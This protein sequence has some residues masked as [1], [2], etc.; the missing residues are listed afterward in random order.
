MNKL[1]ILYD[2]VR[3]MRAKEAFTGTVTVAV[4]KDEA[5]LFSLRNEFAKDLAAGTTKA[6]I[7]T[8]LAYEGKTMKHESVT[9]FSRPGAADD[10]RHREFFRRMHAAHGC[11]CGGVK[12][13]LT[14][15]SCALSLLLALKAEEREDGTV[16][17]SLSAAD[18]PEDTRALVRER[19]SRADECHQHGPAILREFCGAEELDFVVTVAANK[20]YEVEKVVAT[21][22]GTRKDGDG[23]AHDLTA[24]AE[25]ALVW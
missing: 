5:E 10:C 23:A 15:L 22:A 13:K 8:A 17:L 4:R 3:A 24:R 18:L 7:A 16:A 12:G 6:K 25:L 20:N 19:L 21:L 2:V 9:E 11:G 14:R 1:K